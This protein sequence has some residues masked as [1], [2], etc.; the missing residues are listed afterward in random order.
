MV[1]AAPFFPRSSLTIWTKIIW[2]G[3]ITSWILYLLN[4]FFTKKL[5]KKN[6]SQ[7]YKKPSPFKVFTIS[8]NNKKI[9]T[10]GGMKV[11]SDYNFLDAPNFDILLIK[12]VYF[13]FPL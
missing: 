1:K 11:I 9:I 13:I 6:I 8:K 5:T 12:V 4:F 2:L 3:F 10:S 7:I